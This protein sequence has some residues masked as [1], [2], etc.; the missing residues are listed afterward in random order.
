MIIVGPQ[1]T[2]SWLSRAVEEERRCRLIRV[3]RQGKSTDSN[4]SGLFFPVSAFIFTYCQFSRF[5]LLPKRQAKSKEKREDSPAP[6]SLH[7]SFQTCGGS[8]S[9]WHLRSLPCWSAKSSE[10]IAERKKGQRKVQN[11]VNHHLSRL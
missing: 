4:I 9:V 5:Q 8:H 10:D 2:K 7:L 6:V 11:I 3:L 1:D